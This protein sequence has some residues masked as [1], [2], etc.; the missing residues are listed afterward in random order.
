MMKL[1]PVMVETCVTNSRISAFFKLILQV[2]VSAL[3][4]NDK[5]MRRLKKNLF[6][7]LHIFSFFL[8]IFLSLS[9]FIY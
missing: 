6:V 5:N 8:K 9:I 3:I 2:P 7:C 1:F 4:P